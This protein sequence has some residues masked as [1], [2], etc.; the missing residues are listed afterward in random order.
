MLQIHSDEVT[1]ILKS[2]ECVF[3]LWRETLC[4][5]LFVTFTTGLD[6]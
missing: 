1:I 3:T 2:D 4:L 5:S 6:S